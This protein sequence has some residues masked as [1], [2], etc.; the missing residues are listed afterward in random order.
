LNGKQTIECGI[1]LQV[2]AGRGFALELWTYRTASGSD[3]RIA[4]IG[5][6]LELLLDSRGRVKARY[7][8]TQMVTQRVVPLESWCRL[9]FIQDPSHKTTLFVDEDQ[10]YSNKIHD[11]P[12]VEGPLELG[13]EAG[14]FGG[15]LDEV[16]LI[17]LTPRTPIS[18]GPSTEIEMAGSSAVGSSRWI[19]P[20]TP[21]GRLDPALFKESIRLILTG[22]GEKVE[23]TILPNGIVTP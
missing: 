19:L 14:G 17:E 5:K 2:E 16:L 10:A 8:K 21:E 11:P 15:I 9:R 3:Q 23:L 12:L 7:G 13:G 20:F 4:R 18:L 6:I 22:G 1:P